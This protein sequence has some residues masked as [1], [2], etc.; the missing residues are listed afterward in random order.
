M[1]I[2]VLGMGGSFEFSLHK[3]CYPGGHGKASVQTT[4]SFDV[5]DKSG[6]CVNPQRGGM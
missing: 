2:H 1:E 6:I 3:D 5:R 4:G